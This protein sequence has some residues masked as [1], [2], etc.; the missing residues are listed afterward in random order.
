MAIAI[1]VAEF[2][3]FEVKANESVTFAIA[4]KSIKERQ[5]YGKQYSKEAMIQSTK[6]IQKKAKWLRATTIVIA[7]LDER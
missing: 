2:A 4:F 7:K 1:V 5:L 3:L 6:P